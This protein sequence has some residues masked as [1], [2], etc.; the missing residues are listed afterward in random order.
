MSQFEHSSTFP[1]GRDKLEA[2]AEGEVNFW[3]ESLLWAAGY[4]AAFSILVMWSYLDDGF[5]KGAVGPILGSAVVL[6]LISGPLG[7]IWHR[8]WKNERKQRNSN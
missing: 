2:G 1:Y 6:S 4:L 7:T 8:R 3:R 5:P